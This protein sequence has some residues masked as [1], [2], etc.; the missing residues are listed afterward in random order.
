VSSPCDT[1]FSKE[2][3]ARGLAST[4]KK[5]EPKSASIVTTAA[6]L[7]HGGFCRSNDNE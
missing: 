1:L 2:D 3:D 5:H 6:D 4:G 7:Q